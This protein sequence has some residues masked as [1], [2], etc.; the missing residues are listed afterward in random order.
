MFLVVC[1]LVVALV[2]AFY[3]KWEYSPYVKTIDLLPG[4]HKLPIVGSALSVP[5]DPH[6]KSTAFNLVED[7]VL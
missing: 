7:S 4:P 1:I 6:G 2:F 5:R 3:L